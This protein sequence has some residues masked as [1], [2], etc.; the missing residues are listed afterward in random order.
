MQA[1]KTETAGEGT[2]HGQGRPAAGSNTACPSQDQLTLAMQ[3]GVSKKRSRKATAKA[4]Q[5]D[6]EAQVCLS[7]KD[8]TQQLHSV[9]VAFAQSQNL[10][11]AG[12]TEAQG[13]Q[14]CQQ[15]MWAKRSAEGMLWQHRTICYMQC[16]VWDM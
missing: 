1:E 5:L 11:F 12:S 14:N 8:I 7:T 6:E 2:E 10:N 9:T 13:C 15:G 3:S 4:A 16:E